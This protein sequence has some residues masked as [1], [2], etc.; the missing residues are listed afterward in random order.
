MQLYWDETLSESGVYRQQLLLTAAMLSKQ[1]QQKFEEFLA[2]VCN[3]LVAIEP[4]K[5]YK[6]C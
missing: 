3:L 2:F 1:K 6:D 5:T 4:Q